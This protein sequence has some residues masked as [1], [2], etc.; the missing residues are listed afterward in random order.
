MCSYVSK[1]PHRLG[2]RKS[3]GLNTKLGFISIN[4][5]FGS[6][7]CS[8]LC[9]DVIMLPDGP[10]I[11]SLTTSIRSQV[12]VKSEGGQVAQL[13]VGLVFHGAPRGWFRPKLRSYGWSFL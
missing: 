11:F 10:Y 6:D 2:Q 5:S 12:D 1:V 3:I 4:V 9:L 8:A 13:T 7:W